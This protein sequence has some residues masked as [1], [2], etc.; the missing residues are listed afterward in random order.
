MCSS[1]GANHVQHVV[2]HAVERD[3]SAIKFGRVEITFILALFLRLK[4]LPDQ[5]SVYCQ[6]AVNEGADVSLT[7]QP[8]SANASEGLVLLVS[9][10]CEHHAT[11]SVTVSASASDGLVLLV[12]PLCEH[13]ATTSVTVS[14][15]TSEG[16]VLLVSL[17]CEHHATTSV[18]QYVR[19]SSTARFP[20]AV[21][22]NCWQ[23]LPTNSRVMQT[24]MRMYTTCLNVTYNG[25]RGPLKMSTI[26]FN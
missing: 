5:V 22:S 21:A 18:S 1:S 24:C 7:P 26:P 25:M 8:L 20:A 23:I 16:L 3:S 14:A 6:K 15:S 12:S 4:P 10:L 19:G 2:S 9:L 11:T 17:L 13:H